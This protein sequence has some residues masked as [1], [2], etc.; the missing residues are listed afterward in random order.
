MS[1]RLILCYL[2]IAICVFAQTDHEKLS[3]D[4]SNLVALERMWNEAQVA[5]DATAIGSMIGDRF[6]NTEFNGEVSDR[7][8]FLADFADPKFKPSLMNIDNVRVEMYAGTAVV[9][10]TYH[11]KGVYN[12][13]PYEH[14]GRFT[15][16]WVF[17]N[18]KWLCVASHSSLL[19]K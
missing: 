12:G 19:Q 15:D 2:L 6:V 1:S 4:H 13:K 7:K 11:T 14:F 10:G 3:S 18:G 17:E 9:T 8:K 16:T 5:R